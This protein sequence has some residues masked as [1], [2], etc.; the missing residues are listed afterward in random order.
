MCKYFYHATYKPFLKSIKQNGLG[1]TNNKMWSDSKK[2]VVYLADDSE[3]AASFAETAEWLDDL[4]DE[5]YEKY[6]IY[7]IVI[8]PQKLDSKKLFKDK[9]NGENTYEYHGIIPESSFV[10]I[11]KYV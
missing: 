8:D 1:N 7:I 11:Y 9:N 4:S 2:G 5:E 3:Q 6:E 10:F